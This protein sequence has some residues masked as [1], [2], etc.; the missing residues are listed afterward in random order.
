[1]LVEDGKKPESLTIPDIPFVV[2]VNHE[3]KYVAGIIVKPLE[4]LVNTAK[5][6]RRYHFKTDS[7]IEI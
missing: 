3:E 5:E 2:G 7:Y 1:M 6:E 4:R